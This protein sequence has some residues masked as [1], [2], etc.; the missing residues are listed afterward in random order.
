MK[1]WYV[2]KV[3]WLNV[4]ATALMVAALFLPGGEFASLFSAE[5]VKYIALGV[6]VVNIVLRVWFTDT[7]LV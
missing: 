3:V 1:A 5:V 6:S 4:I 2:S 7:K